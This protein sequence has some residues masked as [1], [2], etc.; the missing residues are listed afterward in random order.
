LLFTFFGRKTR[1]KTALSTR[2]ISPSQNMTRN[3][4]SQQNAHLSKPYQSVVIRLLPSQ[5][6]EDEMSDMLQ[7]PRSNHRSRQLPW[8]FGALAFLAVALVT[9]NKT[10]ES[11]SAESLAALDPE[12]SLGVLLGMSSTESRRSRILD[13]LRDL[14]AKLDG[15]IYFP[16]DSYFD[17]AAKVWCIGVQPPM[18]VIEPAHEHDVQLAVPV[19]ANLSKFDDFPFR[20][21]SGGHHKAGYSTVEE[22]AIISLVRL[23]HVELH[24]RNTETG[25]AVATIGPAVTTAIFLDRVLIPHGYGGVIGFCSSVAEGGFALGG[26]LGLQSRMHGLGADNVESMRVVL[27]DGSVLHVSET[28]AVHSDLF[29]ALRGAGGGNFGVVTE[30]NYRVHLTSDDIYSTSLSLRPSTAASV[31]HKLGVLEPQLPGNLLVMADNLGFNQPDIIGISLMWWGR[32]DTEVAAGEPY[33]KTLL[34]SLLDGSGE[35]TPTPPPV[36]VTSGTSSWTDF[37][38]GSSSNNDTASASGG[39]GDHVW[40]AQTWTGFLYPE[41]NTAAIWQDMMRYIAAGLDDCDMLWPDIELWGGA[42]HDKEWYE[43]AFPYRQAVW[44]V[45]V[46]LMIPDDLPHA[47]AEELYREQAA[48]VNAWWPNV[49]KYLTGSYVNYP[50]ITL[51]DEYPR[52]F[53]GDNLPRL[54]EIKQRYD[55]DAVFDFPMSVPTSLD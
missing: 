41:N 52:A 30:M 31:I 20:I 34:D 18:A 19:L 55:P 10:K 53:W 6:D 26:G 43:T 35:S 37:T 32:D 11:S 9:F 46:L 51:G 4:G 21:R 44:N 49:S 39:W 45:G 38:V 3:A 1:R 16:D 40:A 29:W 48:K 23:N 25:S 22:G 2:L 12:H 14:Q 13:A 54:V 24:S 8:V 47:H 5:D 15:D 17:Q 28:T 42:I 33:I 7:N 36:N 27:A 50:M